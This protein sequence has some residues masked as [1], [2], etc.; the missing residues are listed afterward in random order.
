M[1]D[2]SSVG[3]RN[4]ER[5]FENDRYS[6]SVLANAFERLIPDSGKT[7][8]VPDSVQDAPSTKQQ[9]LPMEASQ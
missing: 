6:A 4:V 5:D 7:S 3:E 8:A 1:D 2:Q 9:L